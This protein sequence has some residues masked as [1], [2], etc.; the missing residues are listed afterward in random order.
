MSTILIATVLAITAPG[1]EPAKDA[2]KPAVAKVAVAKVAKTTVTKQVKTATAEKNADDKTAAAKEQP[3]PKPLTG[4]ELKK[5]AEDALRRWARCD[6]EKM[7]AAAAEFIVLYH[8]LLADTAIPRAARDK[9]RH[10]VRYRLL[11]LAPRI[12]KKAFLDRR[13]AERA[14]K[15]AAQSSPT[16]SLADKPSQG[17]TPK[18]AAGGG[19]YGNDD[20]GEQLVELIHTTVLPHTW[21]ANGGMGSMYYWRNGRALVVR[22]SQEAHEQLEHLLLQLRRAGN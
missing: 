2:A 16:K 15:K 21:D 5:A 17:N 8:D 3:A 9:L 12:E 14:A 1:E 4:A 18:G 20:Y 13:K 11:A 10:K 7:S 22:Q 6:E 19:A